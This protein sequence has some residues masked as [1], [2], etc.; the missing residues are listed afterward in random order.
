M[1]QSITINDIVALFKSTTDKKRM[2]T[3]KEEIVL[4]LTPEGVLLNSNQPEIERKVEEIIRE[5]RNSIDPFLKYSGGY[6]YKARQKSKPISP[7]DTPT[8]NYIGK[9]G[10]CAVMSE[11]LFRGYNVNSMMVDEGIDLVAS[12]NNIFYYI[13]VKTKILE[14]QNKFYFQIK[15]DAFQT[16]LG[17]QMRYVLVAHCKI[18]KED[19]NVFFIFSNRDIQ[20][21]QMVKT[22]PTPADNSVYL[23]IKI[24]YDTRTGKSFIYDGRQREEVTFYM[25]NFNL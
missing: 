17:T 13:Q 25:N 1:E 7:S 22:I 6:Y 11:L 16:F 15:Q 24:E 4:A 21:F 10:E 14:E 9:A 18:N 5:D 12:K 19:R 2:K 8:T 20:R 23:S 3:I